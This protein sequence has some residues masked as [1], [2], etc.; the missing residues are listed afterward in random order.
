MTTA[1]PKRTLPSRWAAAAAFTLTEALVAT[2]VGTLVIAGVVTTYIMTIKSFQ[3]LSNYWEIHADGRYAVDRFASDMRAVFAI[4][5]LNNTQL[6]CQIPTGFYPNGLIASNKTVAYT[7]T[8][9]ALYRAET[10]SGSTTRKKLAENIYLLSFNLYDRLG[11][12]TTSIAIAKSIQV[13]IKLRK[14]TVSQV[15]SEDY[16][17]ARLDMRNKP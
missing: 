16:L 1:S 17:S 3:A 10:I 8:G 15:Q 2:S 9:S 6:V 11:N 13:D 7:Y 12:P 4:T 14:F 5:T